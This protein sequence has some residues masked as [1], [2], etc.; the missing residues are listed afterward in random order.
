MTTFKR[1]VHVSNPETGDAA[2]FHPGDEVPDWATDY[3][4]EGNVGDPEEANGLEDYPA[5]DQRPVG[6]ND[7]DD[8]PVTGKPEASSDVSGTYGSMTNEELKDLLAERDLPVSGSKKEL[9]NRL[10]S[11]DNG[12]D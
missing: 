8:S 4:D 3:V 10:V 5:A 11:S 9:V 7:E 6:G 2:W 1:D 12:A